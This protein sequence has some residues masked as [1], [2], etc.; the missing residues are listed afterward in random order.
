MS[1]LVYANYLKELNNTLLDHSYNLNVD[2]EIGAS[3]IVEQL[4]ILEQYLQLNTLELQDEQGKGINNLVGFVELSEDLWR[5]RFIESKQHDLKEIQ[6]RNQLFKKG[7][8]FDVTVVS[9][10]NES[11][12]EI[13]EELDIDLFEEETKEEESIDL[14][15]SE[16][17]EVTD[18]S[19]EEIEE[20]DGTPLLT[21]IFND[22]QKA[23]N[24]FDNEDDLESFQDEYAIIEDDE[25]PEERYPED[26]YEQNTT[27]FGMEE[28]GQLDF[29]PTPDFG[30]PMTGFGD[31]SFGQDTGFGFEQPQQ[32]QVGEKRDRVL[33][34]AVVDKATEA[35]NK[36]IN[37][38][39]K[40]IAK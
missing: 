32:E 27:D 35:V 18:F 26:S 3:H 13:E 2:F 7:K 16:D 22:L 34:D 40:R 8:P 10:D 11:I 14:G 36:G 6:K 39:L 5:R 29:G 4:D 15:V 1:E 28:T 38:L 12:N 24:L 23:Q 21:D 30:N 31:T 33:T 9:F 37:A 17:T 20:D 25:E 19:E